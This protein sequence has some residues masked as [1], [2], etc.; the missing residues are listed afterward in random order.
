MRR[1][2]LR[3]SEPHAGFHGALTALAGPGADQ[4][5]LEFGKA[6]EYRQHQPAMRCRGVRPGVLQAAEAGIALGNGR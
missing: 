5:S 2:L 6:A 1:E 4:F 3:P